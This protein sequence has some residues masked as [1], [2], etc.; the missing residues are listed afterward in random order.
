MSRMHES[1]GSGK[2]VLVMD[3]AAKSAIPV[4]EQCAN[5]GLEVIAASEQRY[6]CGFS[7]R[8][9]SRTVRYPSPTNEQ[10]WL[11]FILNL[12]EEHDIEL[13]VPL[14][15]DT[16]RVAKH[17]DRIRQHT[18]LLIS[19]FD[20]FM[21]G[22]SKIPTMKAA[23]HVGCPIPLTWFPDSTT[24]S[25]IA[26][27][28]VYPLLIKPAV[29]Y[30]ARGLK[31]CHNADEVCRHYA[32]IENEY[33][34]C[35]LQEY[36]PQD[37]MQ[38]KCAMILDQAHQVLSA[39]VY[40]KLR[41]YPVK[42]GSSTLN[43]SVHRPDIIEACTK[44]ATYLEWVGPCD[45]DLITDPRDGIVKLMEINP[46]FSDTYKMA[47]VVGLDFIK[48]LYHL[49]TDQK[50]EPQFEYRKDQYLRFMFGD[51]FWFLKVGP[52][53]WKAQPSFFRF[54][55][56]DITYLMTGTRDLGPVWGYLKQNVRMLWDRDMR[57]FRLR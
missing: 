46:R 50:A 22:L 9:V 44:V 49:A 26:R 19:P 14:A 43:K 32:A 29:S 28:A 33:G 20:T 55:G 24:L 47:Q 54:F 35:F 57:K 27:E 10:A 56:P 15:N 31:V 51:V 37:G 36:I 23:Q 53:R 6:C 13:I 30:G 7:S 21:K 34:E 3:A 18:N 40:E 8:A 2:K 41:Y 16:Y 1:G 17:A 11:E 45:F 39:F 12:L 4:V 48:I 52:A 5:L 42:G 38:Y 25:E